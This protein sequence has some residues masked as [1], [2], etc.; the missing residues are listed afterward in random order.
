M[1]SLQVIFL[2]VFRVKIMM[3][4]KYEFFFSYLKFRTKHV[5][6]YVRKATL[7]HVSNFQ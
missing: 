4:K 5:D 3:T 6:R 1:F 2:H 7:R